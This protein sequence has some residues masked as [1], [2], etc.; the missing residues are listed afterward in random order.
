ML[1]QN[2]MG[3]FTS[4]LKRPIFLQ[5]DW[6]LCQVTSVGPFKEGFKITKKTLEAISP[7]YSPYY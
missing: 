5:K 2:T 4:L 6:M 1:I 7:E 3:H